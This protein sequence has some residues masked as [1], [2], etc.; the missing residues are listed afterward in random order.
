MAAF[1]RRFALLLAFLAAPAL[2][3]DVAGVKFEDRAQ[4]ANADL[5]LNGAGLR[6]RVFF[7]VY[8][9]GLYLRQKEPNAAAIINAPGPKRIHLVTLRDLTAEQFAEA[10]VKS[11]RENHS[12]AEMTKLEARLAEFRATLLGLGQAPERTVITIDHL[13]DAGTRLAVGGSQKG[14][15]IP[16]EDFYQGLLRIWLGDKPVQADLKE[17]LTGR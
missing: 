5:V 1:V 9:M 6:T 14:K 2:A 8:A 4:V 3:A 10:L 15:D 13:P 11:F 7:K 12:E 16:G 17:A